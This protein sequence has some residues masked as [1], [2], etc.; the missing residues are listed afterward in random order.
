MVHLPKLAIVTS[1]N[2]LFG[3]ELT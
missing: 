1:G 2:N 3:V